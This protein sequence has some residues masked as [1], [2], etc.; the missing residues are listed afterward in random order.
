MPLVPAA[1][2]TETANVP[3]FA[4][5]ADA[6]TPF[7]SLRATISLRP[8]VLPVTFS[9]DRLTTAPSTRGVV[10]VIGGR[11][12]SRTQTTGSDGSL[13]VF[14]PT[15][16]AWN[17]LRPLASG[18][19]GMITV[20]VTPMPDSPTIS[21][22][23]SVSVRNRRTVWSVEP[24]IVRGT[25]TVTS[26]VSARVYGSSGGTM[27]GASLTG[28]GVAAEGLGVVVNRPT[29]SSTMPLMPATTGP[30]PPLPIHTTAPMSATTATAS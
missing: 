24:V 22:S 10:T 5:F 13:S 28:S 15:I 20:G 23:W 3:S 17:E 12:R 7:A 1:S 30:T 2:G 29:M 19:S 26:T 11:A 14:G 6:E 21:G 4:A 25:V 8:W 27:T 16:V 18:M 9:T